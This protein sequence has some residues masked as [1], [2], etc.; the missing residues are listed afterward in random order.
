MKHD[1]LANQLLGPWSPLLDS[2]QTIFQ[3]RMDGDRCRYCKT[4]DD[5]IHGLECPVMQ[6]YHG[7]LLGCWAVRLE[8]LLAEFLGNAKSGGLDAAM[9]I[10]RERDRIRKW[11]LDFQQSDPVGKL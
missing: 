10:T 6:A 8:N 3:Q 2:C 4:L 7:L 5:R 11:R 9:H 1:R